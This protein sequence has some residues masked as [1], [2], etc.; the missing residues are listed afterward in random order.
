MIRMS[1]Y[2]WQG[3]GL[4]V[5]AGAAVG[6]KMRGQQKNVKRTVNKAVR[7]VENAFDSMAH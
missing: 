2:F 7:N 1:N 5:L 4:G 3:L 6:A